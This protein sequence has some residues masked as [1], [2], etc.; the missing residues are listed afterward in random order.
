MIN[1]TTITCRIRNRNSILAQALPAWLKFD[2][3]EIVIADFRD[4][5]CE[6]AWDVVKSIPDS[7]IKVIET[8]YEYKWAHGIARNLAVEY[9]TFPYI[10]DMDV[11]YVLKENF[12]SKQNHIPSEQ[13]FVG[14]LVHKNTGGLIYYHKDMWRAINGYDENIIYWGHE[15]IDFRKRLLK[16]G[17]K[18]QQYEID[19][20]KHTPHMH[21]LSLCNQLSGKIEGDCVQM[22]KIMYTFNCNMVS[23][24]PWTPQSPRIK[25]GV[26][27]LEDR[28]FLAIRN[29]NQ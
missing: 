16:A 25:W 1:Q 21:E 9:A 3:P 29:F 4:D 22:K 11:D 15:D 7:R 13:T 6:S 19:C 28:R 23:F 27:Q 8:K 18:E 12:F 10:L 24:V 20:V 2:V 14:R 26:T 5:G 17:Y